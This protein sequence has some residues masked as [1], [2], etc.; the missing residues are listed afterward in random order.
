MASNLAEDKA[1]ATNKEAYTNGMVL[2]CSL[3]CLSR[4][5]C[6]SRL[7]RSLLIW[8]LHPCLCVGYIINSVYSIFD[9]QLHA[10]LTTTRPCMIDGHG[11]ELNIIIGR[12]HLAA[13]TRTWV[14]AC[15]R[16]STYTQAGL[17][18]CGFTHKSQHTGAPASR[19]DLRQEAS[20]RG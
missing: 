2:V 8:P 1:E 12:V 10:T 3:I 6:L 14:T 7:L 18:Q 19:A 11:N 20:Y 13:D 17:L 15:V 5:L 16:R 9:C 4:S